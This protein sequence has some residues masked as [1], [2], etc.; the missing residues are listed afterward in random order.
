[1]TPRLHSKPKTTRPEKRR[2]VTLVAGLVCRDSL[3]FCA[4]SEESGGITKSSV[5]KMRRIPEEGA[6]GVL[7]HDPRT[8][9]SILVSA[10]G[11]GDLGEYA[12]QHIIERGRAGKTQAEVLRITRDILK[13]M[14]KEDVPMFPSDNSDDTDFRLLI[15]IRTPDGQGPYLYSARGITIV[16]REKF[17]S[18][19]SGSVTDYI[20]DQMYYD[21]MPQENG[22]A[23]LL[24]MLQIAKK[25]VSG[26]GGDSQ[27]LV[28]QADGKIEDKPSWE[29]SAEE[30][31]VSNFTAILESCFSR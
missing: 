4:D 24:S 10:A 2:N 19:G 25:Y 13:E 8:E 23:V 16:R 29:V 1:M 9:A 5:Q 28:L 3:V 22:I 30:N 11:N 17:Y 18:W 14:A 27:I 15:G 20:L 21:R 6:I 12:M 26:V 31:I 7:G